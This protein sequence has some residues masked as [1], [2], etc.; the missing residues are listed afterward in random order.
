MSLLVVA[1]CALVLALGRVRSRVLAQGETLW[2]DFLPSTQALS[3]LLWPAVAGIGLVI[4]GVLAV[5]APLELAFLLV[6]GGFF[7]LRGKHLFQDL[8]FLLALGSMSLGYGFANLGLH[9]GGMPIPLTEMLLLPLVAWCILHADS[10]P[11]MG[12]TGLILALFV[13]YAT[14][15][16][17]A[18]FPTYRGFAV[19]DF[20][21]PL[22]ALGLLVGFWSFYQFGLDWVWRF[23]LI[24]FLGVVAYGL[25]MPWQNTLA[26]AGPVVGLQQPVP[27]LGQ[28]SGLGTAV[29]AGFFFFLLR[30]RPPWALLLAALCL[31]EM[32]VLQMRGLYL[33]VPLAFL[34]VTLASGGLRTHLGSKIARTLIVAGALLLVAAPMIPTGRVGPVTASFAF[35]QLGTL[36]GKKGPG[37][38]SYDVRQSWLKLTLHRAFNSDKNLLVGV[39][40]GPDL[41]SGFSTNDR[42]DVRKPHD[43]HLEIFARLGLIGLSLWGALLISVIAPVWQAARSTRLT[44]DE[45]RFLIWSVACMTI[46]L[47]IAATQPLLAFPHG[48]VPLFLTMGI[49]LAIARQ[50]QQ[51]HTASPAVQGDGFHV[52]HSRT[53]VGT[54]QVA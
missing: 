31:G 51:A 12:V 47:F 18:D 43:D 40:L 9:L 37:E 25:L 54:G 53:A 30:V 17:A 7:V 11:P 14:V 22:E 21:M 24:V 42:V 36:L 2:L 34:L 4:I 13:G 38:G 19:R 23:Y 35:S 45:R 10:L 49:A 28:Y 20:T 26:A 29:A 3:G 46:Y 15:H 44:P 41:A 33:V 50:T 5:V 6:S 32:A 16:L 39:G 52:R 48:T 8:L 1:T 27:L